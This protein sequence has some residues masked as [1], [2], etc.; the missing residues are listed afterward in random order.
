MHTECYNCNKMFET[1]GETVK[2]CPPC[3][4]AYRQSRGL[5]KPAG[6]ERK[7]LDGAAYQREY[8]LANP[9]RFKEYEKRRKKRT[10]EQER[11]R[12]VRKMKRLHGDDWK[13]RERAPADPMTKVKRRAREAA[14]KATKTGKLVKLPCWVCGNEQVEAHHPDYSSPLDVVWLCR[15]H[16][17]EIHK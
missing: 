17:Q 5:L 14:K 11:E 10:P 13:P 2:V 12:Y 7:T 6:W 1:S 4:K 3:N 8:R 15:Q 9:E 16:H